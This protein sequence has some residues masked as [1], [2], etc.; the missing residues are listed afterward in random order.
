M[1]ETASDH[2]STD[3]D[4][5][6]QIVEDEPELSSMER[7]IAAIKAKYSQ[8]QDERLTKCVRTRKAP[9]IDERGDWFYGKWTLPHV[10]QRMKDDFEKQVG[11]IFG[12]RADPDWI[13]AVVELTPTTKGKIRHAKLV[14]VT[15]PGT[16]KAVALIANLL[17]EDTSHSEVVG[18]EQSP[19]PVPDHLTRVLRQPRMGRD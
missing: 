11:G 15:N 6:G 3:K 10:R 8:G 13:G 4:L 5:P 1:I 17:L 14:R 12:K 18:M 7:E 16:D 9:P 19:W 2:P